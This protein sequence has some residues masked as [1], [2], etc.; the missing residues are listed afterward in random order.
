ML[1]FNSNKDINNILPF[2]KSVW[3]DDGDSSNV[4][5]IFSALIYLYANNKLN[6]FTYPFALIKR[7]SPD[8]N[9]LCYDKENCKG[10]EHTL[11]TLSD[12]KMA[13]SELK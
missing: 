6:Q 1:Y 12:Y 13:E 9:I 11:S 10:I 7:E 4:H 2:L 3:I 5:E 8:F